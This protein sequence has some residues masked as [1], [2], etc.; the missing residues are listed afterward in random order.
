MSGRIER[1]LRVIPDGRAAP[2]PVTYW[3]TR[4]H[5][6][7][8]LETLKLHREGNELFRKG[9]PAFVYVIRTRNAEDQR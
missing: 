6:E 8:M 1:S 4:S 2:K 5:E 3:R 9:N 7:R